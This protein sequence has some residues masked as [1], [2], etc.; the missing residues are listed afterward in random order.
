MRAG[1]LATTRGG[2]AENSTTGNNDGESSYGGSS[3]GGGKDKD[4]GSDLAP[5]SGSEEEEG[6]ARRKQNVGPSSSSSS[7]STSPCINDTNTMKELSMVLESVEPVTIVALVA[8]DIGA[9]PDT[10]SRFFNALG[11][12][13]VRMLAFPDI[14]EYFFVPMVELF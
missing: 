11:G 9:R 6:G 1:D 13:N 5:S 2:G 4:K 8:E 3:Y 10:V 12:S 14:D 7:S